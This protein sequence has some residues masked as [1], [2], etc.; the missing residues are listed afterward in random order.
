MVT[1]IAGVLPEWEKTKLFT[2]L[3]DRVVNQIHQRGYKT[4]VSICYNP[5]AKTVLLN[6]YLG[7]VI[8]DLDIRKRIVDG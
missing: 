6:F 2:Y 8:N 4:N 1:I 5:R 7:E 3:G